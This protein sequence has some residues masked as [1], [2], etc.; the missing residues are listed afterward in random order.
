MTAKFVKDRRKF[1]RFF[2]SD[3]WKKFLSGFMALVMLVGLFPLT[4]QAAEAPDGMPTD[5][6][7]NELLIEANRPLTRI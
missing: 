3:G 6:T 4:A 1:M 7:L 2:K 5:I